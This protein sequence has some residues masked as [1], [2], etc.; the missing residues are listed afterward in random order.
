VIEACE[1]SLAGQAAGALRAAA[2]MVRKQK[3]AGSAD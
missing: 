2:D 1:T 3:A